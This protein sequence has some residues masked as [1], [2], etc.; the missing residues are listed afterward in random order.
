MEKEKETETETVTV[1]Y[2]VAFEED[3]SLFAFAETEVSFL[4]SIGDDLPSLI[5]DIHL[6][7]QSYQKLSSKDTKGQ[8]RFTLKCSSH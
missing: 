1:V 2:H 7:M 5:A 4:N 6:G 8:S 3:E